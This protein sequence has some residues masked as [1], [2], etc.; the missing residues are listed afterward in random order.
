MDFLRKAQFFAGIGPAHFPA[1]TT[2]PLGRGCLPF[3][4]CFTCYYSSLFSIGRNG[5]CKVR[6]NFSYIQA[7]TPFLATSTCF[8]AVYLKKIIHLEL[9]FIESH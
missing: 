9:F 7:F 1:E 3:S 2:R 5:C 6:N 8:F 4:P